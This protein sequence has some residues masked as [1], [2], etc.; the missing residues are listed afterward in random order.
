MKRTPAGAGILGIKGKNGG[1]KISSGASSFQEFQE[2]SAKEKKAKDILKYGGS[3]AGKKFLFGMTEQ[4]LG[5]EK[6]SNIAAK[7]GNKEQQEEAFSFLNQNKSKND[8]SRA[9]SSGVSEKK[10]TQKIERLIKSVSADIKS[11]I[12]QKANELSGEIKGIGSVVERIGKEVLSREITIGQGEGAQTYEYSP[13]A[14]EGKQVRAKGAGARYASKEGGAT[15]DYSRVLNKAAQ[16]SLSGAKQGVDISPKYEKL[17]ETE[18]KIARQNKAGSSKTVQLTKEEAKSIAK[19]LIA[20]LKSDNKEI[21][22]KEDQ[23]SGK[24]TASKENLPETFEE[25]AKKNRETKNA[26]DVM[27]FGGKGTGRKLLFGMT[28]QLL[29]EEKASNIATKFGNKKQQEHAFQYLKGKQQA[30]LPKPIDDDTATQKEAEKGVLAAQ[31]RD[32]EEEEDEY[33]TSVTEKLDKILEKLD[34]IESSVGDSN[35]G[36]LGG[37]QDL[38]GGRRGRGRGRSRRRGRMPSGGPGVPS[39]MPS[40]APTPAPGTPAPKVPDGAGKTAEKAAEKAGEKVAG[41]AAG[42][43]V[44]KTVLKSVLKKIPVFGIVAGLAFAAGKAMEGDWTGAGMELASGAMG[45]IPVVGTAA[46]LG[47]DATIAARDMGV[48]DSKKGEETKAEEP[49]VQPSPGELNKTAP[50]PT[51][52][53]QTAVNDVISENEKLNKENRG[54]DVIVVNSPSPP[55]PP[56]VVPQRQNNDSGT[57][58]IRN[59]ELSVSTYTASIFDHPVVHPGIYKM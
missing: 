4:F 59:P 58:L 25:F 13:L 34:D 3:G 22:D 50:S 41:K 12:S 2:L 6:A 46:S 16:Q 48:F 9:G 38:L 5:E 27:R 31:A 47:M 56:V 45:S 42:K 8:T 24:E 33:Q 49:P 18:T 43:T 52:L 29:G 7:F 36:G 26:R 57:I 32:E 23:R 28:E 21:A 17:D 19:L 30:A 20:E 53:A 55:Q 39:P 1:G 11:S 40:P 14:P 10:I 51:K 37:L 44:G 15:S 54:P 35:G